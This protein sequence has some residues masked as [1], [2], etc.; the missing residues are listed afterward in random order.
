M[1]APAFELPNMMAGF[2]PANVDLSAEST[3]GQPT[4]QFSSITLVTPSGTGVTSEAGAALALAASGAPILGVLQDNP[5]IGVA[6]SVMLQGISKAKI[7]TGGCTVMQPLMADGLGGFI[8]ATS[9]NDASA[10]ALCAATAGA[11]APIFIKALG[12]R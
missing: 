9:G 8:P 7:G 1:G 10:I 5:A 6:G 4:Y 3:P 12:K 2:W 11:I